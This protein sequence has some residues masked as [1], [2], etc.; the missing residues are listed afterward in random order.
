MRCRRPVVRW[1]WTI[2]CCVTSGWIGLALYAQE[3]IPPKYGPEAVRLFESR[4]YVRE[5]PAPDF[6][7]LMP[8]HLAQ[9]DE[10]TCSATSTAMVINALRA[11]ETLTSHHDL[12][13]PATVLAS[14][15]AADWKDK[16]VSA[17][18][19]VTLDELA[20]L[21]P[22]AARRFELPELDVTAIRF[23]GD[24]LT[25]L[26]ALRQL[27]TEN[28]Q[29]DRDFL[30]ANYL[31]SELTGDPAGAVGHLAPIGAFDA[32]RDRVLL[33]DPDRR[34]YEPYWVPT[35]KLLRA[36]NTQDVVA[37]KP[38]GMLRCKR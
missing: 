6:W 5:N 36:M 10:N 33:L 30:I 19:G 21:I 18:H 7:A 27:L 17:R 31:Q 38:R 14:V 28:E 29:S 35:V 1:S 15:P 13:T 37:N 20:A 34:W 25:S 32:G 11:R 22:Q 23:A 2:L 9:P 4:E 26:K 12:A 3:Q 8:Y 24:E 16:L